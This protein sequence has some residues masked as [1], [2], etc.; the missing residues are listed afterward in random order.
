MKDVRALI[1]ARG[2]S[3][4]LPRK[5]VRE[6]QG[7]PMIDWSVE[8]ALESGVFSTV[9]VTTEDEEIERTARAAGSDVMRRPAAIADDAATLTDVVAHALETW[10]TGFD[11][12][13][14]LLPNCPL[15]DA[16]DI[17]DTWQ[18]FRTRRPPALLSV[19]SYGWTPPFRAL[20]ETEDGLQPLMADWVTRKSQSYPS[21]VCPSGAIYWT[22]P[23]LVARASDLYVPGI[24]GYEL[25]WHHGI[26]ID[27]LNDFELADCIA[28]SMRSGFRFSA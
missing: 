25:P 12:L 9:T 5:N 21:A 26:D 27:T 1:P 16:G 6:F 19:V 14:L 7:R 10:G 28:T 20:T 23:D 24:R 18:V 2:G 8:A 17:R 13:C 3:K 15:R 11:A 4:R 22:T